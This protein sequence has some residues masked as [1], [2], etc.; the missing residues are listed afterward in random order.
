MPVGISEM[1]VSPSDACLLAV[2][3]ALADLQVQQLL[4]KK[5]WLLQ[6]AKL[7]KA[8]ESSSVQV[9]DVLRGV[10]CTNFVYEVTVAGC[11]SLPPA[12]GCAK[13]MMAECKARAPSFSIQHGHGA[14]SSSCML[15]NMCF[16]FADA[17]PVGR[18]SAKEDYCAVWRGQAEVAT[19]HG[20]TEKG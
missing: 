19:G 5:T 13:I 11:H 18:C 16:P 15:S 2:N 4:T 12:C 14:S 7:N 8:L 9:G 20:R 3:L 6:I 17:S 1:C 10:T